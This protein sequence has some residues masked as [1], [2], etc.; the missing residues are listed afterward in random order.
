MPL[1]KSLDNLL[2][3]YF[4]TENLEATSPNNEIIK[5]KIEE[6]AI[7]KIQLSTFQ[8]RTFFSDDK[9]ISLA[10]NIKKQGLLQP[11]LVVKKSDKI[12]FNPEYILMAGER[13]LRA[14]KYLK[15]DTIPAIIKNFEDISLKEQALISASENLHREDL[16]PL[17][18][19]NTYKMLL[20]TQ[21]ITTTEL[22]KMLKHSEQY[23]RN[24]LKLLTLPQ[25]I[26]K[27][28]SKK[29]LTEGQAR[30]LVGLDEKFQ[31]QVLKEILEKE[32]TVKEIINLIKKLK[33]ENKN[34]IKKINLK[35][36]IHNLPDEIIQ[37][38]DKFCTYFP[39]AKMQC[40][41]DLK[42]GKIVISWNN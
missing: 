38:V 12:D 16:S 34:K 36:K 32:L 20:D 14:F 33:N 19:S 41:G 28:L 8:T 25:K 1:G 13:R 21:D 29:K 30:Y 31:L 24:Y 5:T 4:G 7:E 39:N 35:S 27:E 18:L 3:D 15:L 2:T 23:I 17:E 42:K 11:I 6:I 26:Q 40:K 9:I 22:A 10:E 37:K